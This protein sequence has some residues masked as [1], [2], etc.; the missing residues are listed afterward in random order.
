MTAGLFSRLFPPPK[1]LALPAS[2]LDL[3]DRSLKFVTLERGGEGLRLV[4]FG[5]KA[6]PLDVL[7]S[8]QIKNQAALIEI[9]QRAKNEW[10]LE[11]VVMALP[12]ERAYVVRVNL[13]NVAV[14]EE[15]ESI[16][17]QLEEN[18]PLP[19]AEMVFD[20][21]R[22]SSK[23]AAVIVSAFPRQFVAEYEAVL[24][25]AGLR[26]LAL[27]VEA[28]AVARAV[29]P[30]NHS[31]TVLVIDFGKTRTSFFIV[32]AGQVL[33]TSTSAQL[34]GDIMTR[35]IEKNLNLT[36][37]QAETLK[38]QQGLLAGPEQEELAMALVPALSVLRDEILKL[39]DYWEQHLTNSG[40]G[41]GKIAQIMLCGGEAVLP[42]L[43]DYLT[44]QLPLPVALANVWVNVIDINQKVPA[45]DF[46]QSLRYATAIGLALRRT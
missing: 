15:R 23:H 22:L 9:L 39:G 8:G 4:H 24:A 41:E 43:A 12:E 31:K 21:E 42:G 34:G 37:D 2:G 7:Q 46:H 36:A 26:P 27:E 20:Y 5:E 38:L 44:G 13:P 6:I 18:V 1:Y 33:F 25:K 17:L 19:A 45:L 28:Q 11:Q 30:A 3:S 16:E 10:H 14:G 29:V 40:T 32:R 35:A